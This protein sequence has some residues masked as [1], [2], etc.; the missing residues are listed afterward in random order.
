MKT[1]NQSKKKKKNVPVA[2][3]A[4]A[5]KVAKATPA[6]VVSQPSRPLKVTT[7]ELRGRKV[8]QGQPHIIAVTAYDYTFA[9]MMDESV[10][11]ILVG[12]SLGMV[13]QGNKN[14]L[15]VTVD[16]MIYH[17]RAVSHAL[18]HAHLV[19]DM[20]F[21]SYQTGEVDAVRNAGRLVSE[22]GAEAVKIEGGVG[23]SS[24]VSRLVQIG[25]PVM[26]HIGMTP[27]S[28]HV[29]GG[30]KVQGK[31]DQAK[32]S[33]LQDAMA[34]E[35]AGAYAVVVESVPEDLGA[36][37][38]ER[39]KIPVIGIGAGSFCDGQ[40]LVAQDLLGMNSDF[41][42]KF[43]KRFADIGSSVRTAVAQFSEEVKSGK[44]PDKNHSFH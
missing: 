24:I 37:I 18:S 39:L 36:R 26:G 44:F 6:I 43:V 28:V 19:V 13:I 16:D 33:I 17:S 30:F 23:V 38:T 20:P 3:S 35:D 11:V 34:L 4:K 1:E 7:S 22:G 12:D 42:P 9:K 41:K 15:S 2:P 14:T 21:M 32:N 27:Q 8:A 5:P 29:Y 10:D 31:S 25:I 40:I